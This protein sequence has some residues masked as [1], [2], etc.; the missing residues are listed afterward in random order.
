M[1]SSINAAK[2]SL[3]ST[4]SVYNHSIASSS[5]MRCVQLKGPTHRRTTFQS[6]IRILIAS[7]DIKDVDRYDADSIVHK[8]FKLSISSAPKS[9]IF[10]G[11]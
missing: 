2:H 7:F 1:I 10:S 4:S 6:V 11:L 5:K 9:S 8:S 3:Q